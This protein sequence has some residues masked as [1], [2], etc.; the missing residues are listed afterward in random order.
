MPIEPSPDKGGCGTSRS[1]VEIAAREDLFQQ[2]IVSSRSFVV[3]DN[4]TI[5]IPAAFRV[6]HGGPT[7]DEGY[8]SDA[9]V[10]SQI[11]EN[12]IDDRVVMLYKT[13]PN[14]KRPNHNMGAIATHE[15]G[16][17]VGLYHT[18]EGGCDGDGDYVDETPPE[19]EP[20]WRCL[21]GRYT[22]K[23]DTLVD[24]IHNFMVLRMAQQW[25]AFRTQ[26]WYPKGSQPAPETIPAVDPCPHSYCD[27]AR[28]L[29]PE[30]NPCV[31]EIINVENSSGAILC[32]NDCILI[33]KSVCGL[34]DCDFVDRAAKTAPQEM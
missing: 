28:F 6:L 20:A 22:C 19:V 18:F 34:S 33:V 2:T 30:C 23:N 1:P 10:E 3:E 24:P 9:Q 25:S 26:N 32:D 21:V 13:L 16:H 31:A 11:D 7:Y 29:K 5:E 8:L 14:G 15:V 12:P 4:S 27:N 17:S